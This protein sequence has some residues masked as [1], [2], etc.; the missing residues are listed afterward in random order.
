MACAG[1]VRRL[2]TSGWAW[3]SPY[4]VILPD[5]GSRLAAGDMLRDAYFVQIKHC[6]GAERLSEGRQSY[7]RQALE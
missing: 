4:S 5:G 6:K 1:V 3:I 7:I 2:Y